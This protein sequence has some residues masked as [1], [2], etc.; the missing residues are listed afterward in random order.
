M[1]TS[2]VSFNHL[3]EM[4]VK[5]IEESLAKL[6]LK[7]Q[8]LEPNKKQRHK[9]MKGLK[10]YVDWF[11]D[12]IDT[13]NAH[14]P[15]ASLDVKSLSI[16]RTTNMQSLLDIYKEQV[17]FPGLNTGSGGFMGFIPNGGLFASAV[18]DF[19]AAVSNEYAALKMASPGAEAMENELLNWMKGLFGYSDSSIGYLTSGGTL[20]TLTAFTSARNACNIGPD[21]VSEAVV[22]ISEQTH[23]STLKVLDIIGLRSVIVRKIKVNYKSQMSVDELEHCV[24]TDILNGLNP[25]LIVGTA[26]TTHC[27]AIDPLKQIGHIA[28]KYDIWYHIDAAYGGFFILVDSVKQKLQ[29]IEMSDSLVVDPHKSLFIPYGLGAV[30]IKEKSV[31][32][33]YKFGSYFQDLIHEDLDPVRTSPELTRHF[34][35]PR[36]WIPLKLY[37]VEPFR[38]CLQEKLLLTRYFRI[39]IEQLGLRMGPEPDLSV[40][41]F[42]YMPEKGDV[43][44]FNRGLLQQMLSY[45]SIY[46]TSATINNL[47]VIRLAILSFRTKKFHIDKCLNVIEKSLR[48]TKRQFE[49]YQ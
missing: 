6:N 13:R 25:F 19:M 17:N 30:L 20:A 10:N 39:K 27:G 2:F 32:P 31:L 21:N 15:E 28:K 45:G 35:G 48:K 29:G 22:Y 9:I 12:D 34:R 33:K 8:Q 1:R 36:M 7:S 11:I 49:E 5:N 44:Q 41:Y 16:N 4:E 46:V 43:N 24:Q 47:F 42:W 23:S 40:T 37:G 3:D 38:A 26:G 18:G 14:E